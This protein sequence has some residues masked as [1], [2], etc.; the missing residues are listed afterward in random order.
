MAAESKKAV[1]AAIIGNA[2]IAAIKFTAGL[3]TGSSAMI[4]EGIHSIVD[5]GNGGLLFYGL[6]R[7]ARPADKNHPF[8]HGM[9]V[10]FWSLIVA[11]SIFG[12]G[13]GM[14]IYEGITHVR[15]PTPLESPLINYIVL[16]AA[17]VFESISFSIA[18]RT[19][20][21]ARGSKGTWVAIHHGKDPSMFAVLFEDTAALFGLFIA[22]LG[23]F[24]SHRYNKPEL[25]G[26]ASIG[27][28]LI[29]ICAAGWLAA[30]SK[31]LLVGESA[32]P[33]L[34]DAMREI[35]SADPAVIGIG[36]MLTMHM[37]PDDVL[38]NVELQFTAGLPAEDI[39]A[40]IHRIEAAIAARF[41]EVSRVFIEVEVPS[42]PA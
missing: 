31:S 36:Q 26:A 22:F 37:G 13:G 5:T 19:F 14:S 11:V 24:L 15:H 28:G 32:S 1:V 25:D 35:V 6:H 42:P 23:V 18:W 4:S 20:S 8:G 12:I 30:E 39:H 9:E 38:L 7:S 27:I 10:Y 3:I 29:L 2:A 34:E 40:A 21:S 33:E 41:P 16:A 17:A